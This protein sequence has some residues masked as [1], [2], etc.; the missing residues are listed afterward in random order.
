MMWCLYVRSPIGVRGLGRIIGILS[1]GLKSRTLDRSGTT[2]SFH[3]SSIRAKYEEYW[4]AHHYV[5]CVDMFA[6]SSFGFGP[7]RHIN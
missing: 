4:G 1:F 6:N 3:R 5:V 2:E 7:R